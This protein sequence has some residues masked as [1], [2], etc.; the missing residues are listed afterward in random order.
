MSLRHAIRA[1]RL[2]SE[3]SV[4]EDCLRHPEKIRELVRDA[5]RYRM[6]R[7]MDWRSSAAARIKGEAMVKRAWLLS[8]DAAIDEN[9]ER[10]GSPSPQTREG[11]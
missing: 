5:E 3:D 7:Q 10:K 9:I 4:I 11:S 2:A 6:K 8:Y 1:A